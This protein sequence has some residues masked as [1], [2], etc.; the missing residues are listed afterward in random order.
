MY[1]NVRCGDR[2]LDALEG[3]LKTSVME[4]GVRRVKDH[5]G[6]VEGKEW[7]GE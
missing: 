7:D 1:G 2:M 3:G 5:D 4:E 6:R